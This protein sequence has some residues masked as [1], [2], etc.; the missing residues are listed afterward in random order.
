MVPKKYTAK[1]TFAG[2][3]NYLKST[4]NVKVTVKKAKAKIK[5]KKKT[6]KAKKK[7][8]KFKITLKDNKGKP[9]KKAKVR[10]IVKYAGNVYY[11]AVS[12]KVT[13]KIK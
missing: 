11:K 9:I 5:A 8:K 13:I 4:A 7:T 2:N 12:K 3:S 6:Y 1:V 10:L